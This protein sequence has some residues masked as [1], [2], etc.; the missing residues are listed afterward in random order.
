MVLW[1]EGVD[2]KFPMDTLVLHKYRAPDVLLSTLAGSTSI[3]LACLRYR[4]L[5]AAPFIC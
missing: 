2:V 3:T 5:R 1:Y 4:R